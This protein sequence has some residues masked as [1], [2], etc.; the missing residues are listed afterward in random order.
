MYFVVKNLSFSCRL[1]GKLHKCNRFSVCLVVKLKIVLSYKGRPTKLFYSAY[2]FKY[3][4][5][6][7]K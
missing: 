4:D 5:M 1:L 6:P 2:S 7:S 3:S